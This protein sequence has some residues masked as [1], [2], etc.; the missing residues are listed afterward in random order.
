MAVLA[1][2]PRS[3]MSQ[4]LWPQVVDS[5]TA[6]GSEA[7]E[8]SLGVGGGAGAGGAL[9]YP[10]GAA[11]RS[12]F[13]SRGRPRVVLIC[14]YAR[15]AKTSSASAPAWRLESDWVHLGTLGTR[16]GELATT[17]SDWP[18]SPTD[19]SPVQS[20]VRCDASGRGGLQQRS[21]CGRRGYCVS[22]VLADYTNISVRHR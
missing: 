15:P 14:A 1:S 16:A 22:W 8:P 18:S 2:A 10:G 19:L 5:T 12:G 7:T 13:D 17:P 20:D 6:R 3:H 21:C 11:A 4:P 9:P